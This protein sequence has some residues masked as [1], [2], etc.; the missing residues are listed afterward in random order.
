M[1]IEASA[2]ATATGIKA[3]PATPPSLRKDISPG[4]KRLSSLDAFRGWTM[5]WIVGGSAL[6][7]GLQALNANPVI[8]GLVY[9]LN[10]SDWQGLR[11]YDLIWPSF[12]LMTGMS[13]P[14]S[15]AKRSLTQTHRQILMRVL[16]R[17]L[18]LFLL[19]SLRESIHFNHPYLVEL[20][21]ALQPI[22]VAYLAAFLI[23]RRSWRFQAAVGAGILV[24][25]ALLLAFVPAPG[26]PA[27]SYDRSANLVLWTDLV[28]VGR[29]LPEHWGTVIC[30]LPT[31]ST[32]IVGMLLGELLMTNRSTASKMKTIGLVGL[33]G[34]VL[35][36]A[37]N[38]VIPIVMKIWT[39]SYGLASA[40][41][42]CL[43]FL[44]FYWLVDVRGYRKLAFPFLV[45]GMNAVAIYMSESII[46]WS[47]I[48]AIF[49]DPLAGTLGS[50][51]PLFHAIAVLTVEWLVLYWMYKRK[52]FL[53]A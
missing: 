10:H 35:G 20:S 18:V 25:Y 49:T 14:F 43:M 38:P 52:I 34:V 23:V 1:A 19:G 30:T 44:V 40:G 2:T 26:V 45:I 11:F 17:F 13:L 22:A 53:T 21:S 39:T 24:F 50:F 48:V 12:M 4:S 16:R 47:K 37:L 15:Y 33:S 28:T 27:G 46:P 3:E 36:W 8:N 31:I 5:F 9:E 29:V 7:A 32:T 41:F 42:A 51:T 6:V